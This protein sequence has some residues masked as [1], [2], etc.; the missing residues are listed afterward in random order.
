[1]PSPITI[2]CVHT[3]KHL[4]STSSDHNIVSGW[5]AMFGSAKLRPIIRRDALP[6]I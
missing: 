1:M 3:A 5:V 4:G 6:S 2:D